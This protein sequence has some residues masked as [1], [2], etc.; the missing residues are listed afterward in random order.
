MGFITPCLKRDNVLSA[1]RSIISAP[2]FSPRNFFIR[3]VFVAFSIFFVFSPACAEG[4]QV[5]SA[6]LE[7]VEESIYQLNADFEIN[8]SSKLEEA[9]TKGLPVTFIVEFELTRPRWYWF[10]DG[11]FNAQQ[12]LK[13]SYN[14]L[15]RQYQLMA[16]LTQKSFGSLAEVKSE[17]GKIRGW[18]LFDHT[19]LKKQNAYEA[20]LRIRLDVSQLPKPL[21]VNAL[22]SKD[23]NLDSDWY[24][25][26]VKP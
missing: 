6:E 20:A 1:L 12:I 5:K 26:P 23:W 13:L 7:L 10:N 3:L 25:W 24:R 19:F 8:F 2:S 22:A 21:Q 15:T 17:L 4:I 9:I 11:V 14:A 16:G 18:R